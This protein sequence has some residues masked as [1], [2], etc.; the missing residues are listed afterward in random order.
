MLEDC[1]WEKYLV[2]FCMEVGE[3]EDE[4]L[5]VNAV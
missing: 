3:E 2:K 1:K 4:Y 5:K